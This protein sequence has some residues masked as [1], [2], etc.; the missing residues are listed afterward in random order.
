MNFERDSLKGC[1]KIFFR[2]LHTL[3]AVRL[4]RAVHLSRAVHLLLAITENP[5]RRPGLTNWQTHYKLSQANDKP[6]DRTTGGLPAKEQQP[7][8]P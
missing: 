6:F 7:C 2:L 5:N 1:K 3:R 8:F 4:L